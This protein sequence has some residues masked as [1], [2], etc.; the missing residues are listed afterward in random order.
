MKRFI[1]MLIVCT[2]LMGTLGVQVATATETESN[3]V[4]SLDLSD[5][6]AAGTVK[7]GVTGSAEG[8]SVNGSTDTGT[9]LTPVYNKHY[10]S[11]G[12][13]IEALSF[14][15]DV[16]GANKRSGWLQMTPALSN[17]LVDAD[18]EFTVEIW[19]KHD[20]TYTSGDSLYSFRSSTNENYPNLTSITY[21]GS[22]Y[23]EFRPIGK[24]KYDGTITDSWSHY[25]KIWP[26]G[27][28]WHHYVIA[29]KWTYTDEE[30][31]L[32]NWDV[33]VYMDGVKQ[34]F[35]GTLYTDG[36]YELSDSAHQYFQIGGREY[37]ASSQ[38]YGGEIAT[39][40][41]YNTMLDAETVAAK[42]KEGLAKFNSIVTV[43]DTMTV[44]NAATDT[45]MPISSSYTVSFNNYIDAATV[46]DITLVDASGNE[47]P[48]VVEADGKN[49]IVTYGALTEDATY[50][51][52]VGAGVKSIN[53]IAA[54]AADIT[55]TAS[56]ST[57]IY[58]ESFEVP[59]KDYTTSPDGYTL[60]TAGSYEILTA[61]D[62]TKYLKL[63]HKTQ[64]GDAQLTVDF[65]TDRITEPFA[66]ELEM[67]NGGTSGARHIQLYR[68]DSTLIKFNMYSS[69][70][71][72]S[73]RANQLTSITDSNFVPEN[74]IL[75]GATD[76]NGFQKGKITLSKNAT[77]NFDVIR[78]DMLATEG[79]IL[80]D[81]AKTT[82]VDGIKKLQITDYYG[83][84]DEA[85]ANYLA[86]NSIKAY[87][88][89]P[90]KVLKHNVS[91]DG[92]AYEILLSDNLDAENEVTVKADGADVTAAY[93]D[94]TRTISVPMSSM[95]KGLVSIS[96]E[97]LRSDD[98]VLCYDTVEC[99]NGIKYT[100]ETG[101]EITYFTELTEIVN[102]EIPVN[103]D[104]C[105]VFMAIYDA[106]GALQRVVNDSKV[107][108]LDLEVTEGWTL[109]CLVWKSMSSI[110][111]LV[112][113]TDNYLRCV[114][115]L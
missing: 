41:L 66:I 109:K 22:G 51:L 91:A 60:N 96:L 45:V 31:G 53:G 24:V 29:R 9:S 72:N 103:S 32:G 79:N 78:R 83:S 82:T 46:N 76:S 61:V 98:D 44:T 77:D 87:Y 106:D 58:F 102:A 92:S 6:A 43:G 14:I 54:T 3:L 101:E 81:V 11:N 88:V 17:S 104:D 39:F 1:S 36:K 10:T 105:V 63:S 27:D 15:Q 55:L 73:A 48:V 71:F 115:G 25:S 80:S 57:E 18:G 33:A 26:T 62:G 13:S 85:A 34:S 86:I 50:T 90:L 52:K 49:A 65:G 21:G 75:A 40:N 19:A 97:G 5:Y 93:N 38:S 107:E 110:K 56:K 2:L 84:A 70:G 30:N 20:S 35:T 64:K 99:G 114:Y 12:A 111:P 7:N 100:D 108:L 8:I 68:T 67:M 4:F 89:S 113:A 112:D 74:T 95:P 23:I 42:H 69:G 94:E 59:E 47:L 28:T 16:N 37:G